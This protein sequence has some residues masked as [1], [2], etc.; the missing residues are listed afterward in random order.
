MWFYKDPS[1]ISGTGAAVWLKTNFGPICHHRPRTSPLSLLCTVPSL[2]PFLN[3]SWKSCSVKVFST[4]C[5]SASVTWVVPKWLP[6]SFIF[7]QGNRKVGWVGDVSHVAFGLKFPGEKRIET[8][9]CYYWTDSYFV[10]KV[11][12]EVFTHFHTVVVK[13]H[14]SMWNWPFGLQGE[15]S[16]CCQNA[17]H[18]LDIAHQLSHVFCSWW[19]W[20]LCARLTLSSPK[21]VLSLPGSPSHCF[22][23]F[24]QNLM[25]FLCRIHHEISSGKIHDPK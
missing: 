12:A 18:A 20:T 15:P 4:A 25:L 1:I 3:A 14:D 22:L 6:F 2:L 23:R 11:L 16:P 19:V 13:C 8:V 21:V 24:S 17:E 9:H 5:G 7:S 10:M